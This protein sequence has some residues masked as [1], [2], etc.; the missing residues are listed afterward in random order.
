MALLA[1][2]KCTLH[3]YWTDIVAQWWWHDEHWTI[4]DRIE[5]NSFN[6]MMKFSCKI[7]WPSFIDSR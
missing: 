4:Y 2:N 6:K 3:T 7:N 1:Q 5:N